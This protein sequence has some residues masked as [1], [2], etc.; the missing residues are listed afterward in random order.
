[1]TS[2]ERLWRALEGVEFDDAV[3]TVTV[4]KGDLGSLLR[5]SNR[6]FALVCAVRRLV[7]DFERRS[8]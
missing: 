3:D 8:T 6:D 1:M 2:R 7:S 4:Q 5:E